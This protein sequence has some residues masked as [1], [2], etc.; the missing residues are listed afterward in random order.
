METWEFTVLLRGSG[1]DEQEAWMDAVDQFNL[2]PG[3]VPE[4][5]VLDEEDDDES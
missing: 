2:D 5:A 4:A 1:A 3:P